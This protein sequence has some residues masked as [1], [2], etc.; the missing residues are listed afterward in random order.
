MPCCLPCCLPCLTIVHACQVGMS[1]QGLAHSGTRVPAARGHLSV[2]GHPERVYVFPSFLSSGRGFPLS[3]LPDFVPVTKREAVIKSM[4]DTYYGI[5][6]HGRTVRISIGVA[7]QVAARGCG[8]AADWHVSVPQC[9]PAP[10]HRVEC[11]VPVPRPARCF[12]RESGFM[13]GGDWEAS[14][15]KPVPVPCADP[16]PV[17]RLWSF[18]QRR[19]TPPGQAAR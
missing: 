10:T 8:I 4:Q 15:L 17:P 9:E 11:G 18:F 14:R 16:V 12:R 6:G 5:S 13:E 19:S 1:T 2:S 3:F 7:F